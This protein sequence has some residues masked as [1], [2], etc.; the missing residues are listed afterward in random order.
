MNKISAVLLTTF[1]LT[2]CASMVNGTSQT[3]NVKAVD[4][5]T[6]KPI[7]GAACQFTTN[8]N[9]VY[10][11][12]GNPGSFEIDKDQGDLTANCTAEGYQ[13]ERMGVT[14]DMDAWVL[15]DLLFVPVVIID[16]ADSAYHKYPDYETVEMNSTNK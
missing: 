8:E 15:G 5:S 9:K 14:Q 10:K 11:V 2:G 13:Q 16:L 1:A 12:N 3:I 4:S 7:P 6:G